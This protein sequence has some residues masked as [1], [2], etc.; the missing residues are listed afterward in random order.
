MI[1]GIGDENN[2][3][4]LLKED[5]WEEYKNRITYLVAFLIWEY[6]FFRRN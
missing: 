4:Y 3:V 6:T 2:K 1:Y 5:H